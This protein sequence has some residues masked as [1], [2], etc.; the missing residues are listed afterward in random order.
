MSGGQ[1]SMSAT[2]HAWR[3]RLSPA[4]LASVTGLRRPAD[5]RRDELL[6]PAA[7]SVEYIVRLEQGHRLPRAKARGREPGDQPEHPGSG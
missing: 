7:V 2:I 3:D 6:E 5:L 4:A 1:T